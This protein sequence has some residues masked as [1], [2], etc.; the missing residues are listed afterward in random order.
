MTRIFLDSIDKNAKKISISG[1][2]FHYLKNVM[3]VKIGSQISIF[4]E[5]IELLVNISELEKK[6]CTVAVE[7]VIRIGEI[8]PE[9]HLFQCIVKGDK[10]AEI[11]DIATQFSVKSITPIISQNCY[12]KD[13]NY[14]RMKA[15]AKSALQQSG[16]LV[17]PKFCE[18]LKLEKISEF[19]DKDSIIFFGDLS[20]NAKKISD[21]IPILSE[22][23]GKKLIGIIGPEGG[24]DEKEREFLADMSSIGIKICDRILRAENATS[25]MLTLLNSI[26]G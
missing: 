15:V 7:R 24:F 11:I 19:V 18:I 25:A 4:N 1:E 5:E 10:M 9:I 17:M 2:D 21:F 8:L 13:F 22:F 6:I 3:R 16:G 26:K 14:E 12:V 23:R 20:E